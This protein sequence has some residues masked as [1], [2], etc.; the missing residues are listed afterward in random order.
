MT[1]AIS[2]RTAVGTMILVSAVIFVFLLWLLYLREPVSTESGLNVGFLPPLNAF[3][4]ALSAL[5]LAAGYIAIRNKNRKLHQKL[6]LSALGL[7]AAFLVSYLIYHTFHG[8]TPFLGEGWIRPVY[9]FIL[10]SHVVLSAVML[11][12]IL[13]T[14]YFALTGK[15][16]LHPKLRD[17]PYLFG[18]MFP[19]QG[20]WSISCFTNFTAPDSIYFLSCLK[21]GGTDF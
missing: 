21:T 1:P 20:C 12:L 2:N 6:M 14:L 8:D 9:F 15:L 19:S 11:P 13:I 10:I 5:C 7:S 4:N 3:L 17:T 18:F 16:N